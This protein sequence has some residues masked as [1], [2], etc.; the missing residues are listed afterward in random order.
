MLGAIVSDKAFIVIGLDEGESEE[1]RLIL[2][3]LHRLGFARSV[4]VARKRCWSA[5][6][7]ATRVSSIEEAPALW[8]GQ[9]K[10]ACSQPVLGPL[11]VRICG[12]ERDQERL[13]VKTLVDRSCVAALESSE[14]AFVARLE[15]EISEEIRSSQATR[16]EGS[17]I[18][19]QS[20]RGVVLASLEAGKDGLHVTA[21]GSRDDFAFGRRM[22]VSTV[23]GRMYLY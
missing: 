8:L 22:R 6:R 23:H 11:K 4:R 21:I 16:G 12:F 14:A 9:V 7:S 18:D 2:G 17:G 5:I 20:V 15:P 10:T 1:K 3:L 13:G 19:M